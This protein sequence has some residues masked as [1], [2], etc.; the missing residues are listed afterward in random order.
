MIAIGCFCQ[1]LE[2][3]VP[4]TRYIDQ[5]QLLSN[6]RQ[7]HIKTTIVSQDFGSVNCCWLP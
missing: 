5:R 4:N 6:S 1:R 3:I 2:A 7:S